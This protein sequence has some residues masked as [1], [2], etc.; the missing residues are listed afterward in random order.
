[1][2]NDDPSAIRVTIRSPCRPLRARPDYS[3]PGLTVVGPGRA[4]DGA[5]DPGDMTIDSRTTQP[6]P[7]R[8]SAGGTTERWYA[9]FGR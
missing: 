2:V 7:R 8:P 5:R 3:E 9:L 1:V 4:D 6:F